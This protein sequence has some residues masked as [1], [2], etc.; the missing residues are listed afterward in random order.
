[1]HHGAAGSTRQGGR[2]ETGVQRVVIFWLG[3]FVWVRYRSIST[4]F[5]VDRQ[6]KAVSGAMPGSR[7]TVAASHVADSGRIRTNSGLSPTRQL[8]TPGGRRAVSALHLACQAA[9][10]TRGQVQEGTAAS[11]QSAV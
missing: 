4:S 5:A 7:E 1:M 3:Q 10:Q 2:L 6:A 11:N 9:A 8:D